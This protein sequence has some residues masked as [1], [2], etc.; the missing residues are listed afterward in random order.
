M[1]MQLKL[2]NQHA[3]TAERDR[4]LQEKQVEQ[5]SNGV[6]QTTST[7]ITKVTKKTDHHKEQKDCYRCGGKH[8]AAECKQSKHMNVRIARNKGIWPGSARRRGKLKQE[9]VLENQKV[10]TK[11]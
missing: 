2:L 8:P 4:R 7:P 10:Q 6:T 9:E 3:E 5:A 1:R 11:Y